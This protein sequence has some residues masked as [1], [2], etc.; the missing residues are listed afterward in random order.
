MVKRGDITKKP[1]SRK[2][3]IRIWFVAHRQM[4]GCGLNF[5]KFSHQINFLQLI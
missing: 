1:S 2:T 3:N 5:L 4:D